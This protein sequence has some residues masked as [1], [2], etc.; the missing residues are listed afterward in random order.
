MIDA[1]Y[2]YDAGELGAGEPSAEARGRPSHRRAGG[3]DFPG[4]PSLRNRVREQIKATTSQLPLEE[5]D[6]V[7]SYIN[8]F[9]SPK[10]KKTLEAGLRRSGRYKAMIERVLS[11]EGLPQE[12]IFLA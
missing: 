11:E 3:H 9:S 7:I 8:Y 4:R 6:A 1:I 5:S 12:L 10:G 2:R